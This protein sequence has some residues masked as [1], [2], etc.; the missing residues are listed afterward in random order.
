MAPIVT[1]SKSDGRS[2]LLLCSRVSD[3]KRKASDQPEDV[4]LKKRIKNSHTVT[5]EKE[6]KPINVVPFPEKV[7]LLTTMG[8]ADIQPDDNLSQ[9]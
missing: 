9:Q 5:P 3:G 8:H 2:K 4:V 6:K 1:E 7:G